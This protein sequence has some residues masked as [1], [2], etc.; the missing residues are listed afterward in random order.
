[1]CI[2]CITFQSLL[3]VGVGHFFVSHIYYSQQ[4]VCRSSIVPYDYTPHMA[5]SS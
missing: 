1:L 5:N 2:F 4:M 3:K